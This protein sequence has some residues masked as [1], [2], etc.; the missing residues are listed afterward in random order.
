M[1][2]WYL[3][4][5]FALSL[6]TFVSYGWDKRQARLNRWRVPEKNL[7]WMTWLGGWPGAWAGQQWFRHKT[8]KPLFVWS[9]R[10][11]AL[12][13]V[14]LVGGWVYRNWTAS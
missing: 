13:H 11:A 8:Q 14:A 3:G 6:V 9:V 1:W 5:L 4:W 7:H 10:L 12:L 2:Q